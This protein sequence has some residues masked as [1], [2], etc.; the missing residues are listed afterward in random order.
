MH[1]LLDFWCGYPQAKRNFVPVS[2]WHNSK[3]ET[4]KMYLHP[5]FNNLSLNK[6][7]NK[8]LSKDKG[9]PMFKNVTL[10][11]ESIYIDSA[12]ALCLLPLFEKPYLMMDGLSAVLA[13]T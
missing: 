9:F 1:R 12:M 10:D 7:I 8:Y 4:T 13:T 2:E 3:W 5:Q 6:Y 11:K